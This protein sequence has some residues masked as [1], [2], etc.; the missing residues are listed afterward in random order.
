MK[1]L[2]I[3]TQNAG[4]VREF[5]KLLSPVFSCRSADSVSPTVIE[6]GK[7]YQENALKK[8]QAFYQVY[9]TPVL[10]D[11]SGLE[12]D[13]L[14][15]APG[16]FSARYGSPD[17][18]W[19]ERFEYLYQQLKGTPVEQWSAR[20]RCVLCYFDGK[21]QPFFFEGTCEGRIEPQPRGGEGFGYDPLFF[22]FDLKKGFGEASE[23]EKALVSHRGRAVQAFLDW[24]TKNPTS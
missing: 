10:A 16:I 7:T 13:P 17:F 21:T 9:Q 12:V 2:L 22:S 23:A 1:S 15:G 4:K 20:F 8:A 24:I 14:N 18:S 19:K 11:D 5:Q 3:A 6:D